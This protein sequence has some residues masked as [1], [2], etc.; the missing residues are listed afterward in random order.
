MDRMSSARGR[1]S[2]SESV[3][4]TRHQLVVLVPVIL[5]TL[6]VVLVVAFAIGGDRSAL[7]RYS[8]CIKWYIC[9]FHPA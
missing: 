5:L 8:P 3:E 6:T 9:E 4:I 2:Q 1:L 7:E